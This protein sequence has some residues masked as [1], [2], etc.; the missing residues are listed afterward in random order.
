MKF[1][2]KQ[3]RNSVRRPIIPIHLRHGARELQYEA[4]VDSGADICLF[5]W[6]VGEG[7][8]IDIKSGIPCEVLGVSGAISMYYLHKV[9]LA[10]GGVFY[11]AEIGFVG[12][13]SSPAI[14][15]GI[16][17]QKGL[18]DKFIVRFD[19]LKGELALKPRR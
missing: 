19:F 16:L 13:A 5:D 4:L 17:G 7:L 11:K 15:Y 14:S 9:T 6:E 2:Y 10:I 8:G 1:P 3:Y 18:F 12:S